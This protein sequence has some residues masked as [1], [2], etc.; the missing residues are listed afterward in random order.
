MTGRIITPNAGSL[1]HIE[2]VR[3]LLAL[4]APEGTEYLFPSSGSVVQ[5]LNRALQ[6]EFAWAW[7]L[8]PDHRFHPDLLT[9]LLARE[10]DVVVPLC[11]KRSPPHQ[12]VIGDETSVRDT[13]TGREYP[14]YTPLA[15]DRVPDTP[16][17]VE[18]AGS[19]GLLVR[20]HVLDAIGFPYFESS[21]GLY[22]NEDVVFSQ[23][24]RR[25]GFQILC[26]PHAHLAHIASV[27]V[28]PI[29]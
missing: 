7:L 22:L 14:A 6:G 9:R 4:D 5:N 23:R 2:F 12:L 16:F 29:S 19:A 13:S 20:K 18:I 15:L 11:V 25:A 26:D 28:W 10:A 3:D 17:T 27:P 8:A 24:V 21:D 1:P